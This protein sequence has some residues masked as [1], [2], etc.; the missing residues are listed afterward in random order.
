[1]QGYLTAIVSS[2][3]YVEQSTASMVA[4]QASI[5]TQVGQTFGDQAFQQEDTKTDTVLAAYQ[6]GVQSRSCRLP[7]FHA[8]H[9]HQQQ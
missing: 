5:T 2:I 6:V 9:Q 4:T 8:A 7:T 3:K 1:M